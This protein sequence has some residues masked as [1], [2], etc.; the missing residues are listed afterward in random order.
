MTATGE[1]LQKVL[2]RAGFGS[3]RSAE[4]LIAAGRVLVNGAPAELGRRVDISKDI[5]EVDGS[6]VPVDD[7]LVYYLF[8]KPV[9]VVTTASDESG[10]PTVLELVDPG[11]RIWPVGRLD[12]D[13][14]GA[15]ILCNDG[16][17]TQRLTHPSHE[18]PKTYLAEVKGNVKEATLRRLARGIELEDGPT[19]PAEVRLTDR[20]QGSCLI[21]ITMHEGRNR[22]VRRMLDAVGHPVRRLV[23]T[24]IGSLG[25]GRLKPGTLR[26]LSPTEVQALYR[27]SSG[28][29]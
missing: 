18:V 8:N 12:M 20:L 5:V 1:R 28:D 14:E 9:G 26:R 13:S 15:L 4:E 7:E 25:L 27:E 6:R 3:R 2:A 19:R 23:R 10:R 24:H 21:E 16:D 29:K 11:R 17:L 22:Q